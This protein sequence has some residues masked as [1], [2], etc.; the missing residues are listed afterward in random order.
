MVLLLLLLLLLLP[1]G[2]LRRNRRLLCL[3]LWLWL[4]LLAAPGRHGRPYSRRRL[5]MRPLLLLLLGCI[6]NWRLPLLVRLRT[7]LRR[8][9]QVGAACRRLLLLLVRRLR[10]RLRLRLLSVVW[11]RCSRAGGGRRPSRSWS[12][13]RAVRLWLVL[14]RR[15]GGSWHRWALLWHGH[16]G[17]M[18]WL[19]RLLWLRPLQLLLHRLASWLQLLNVRPMRGGG[20][21][22]IRRRHSLRRE[23]RLLLRCWLGR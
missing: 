10:L 18:L 6:A 5:L 2:A 12:V 8:C 23:G 3:W 1:C 9:R 4:W 21:L 11:G 16:I 14:R 7:G 19:E 15:L 17:G 20:R 13:S 22:S